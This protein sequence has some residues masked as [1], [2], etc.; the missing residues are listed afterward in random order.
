MCKYVDIVVDTSI[1][2]D[3]LF[4]QSIFIPHDSYVFTIIDGSFFACGL[5]N[6]CGVID[7]LHILLSQKLDKQVIIIFVD[8]YIYIYIIWLFC[9]QFV[10]WTSCLEHIFFCSQHNG[11]WALV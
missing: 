3:K 9:K 4:T 5:P 11:T 2:K 8:Y 1:F 7:R 6:V 10:T